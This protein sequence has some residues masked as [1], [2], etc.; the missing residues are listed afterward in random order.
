[1]RY[2]IQTKKI[3]LMQDIPDSFFKQTIYNDIT[4]SL[5]A[6]TVPVS[7]QNPRTFLLEFFSF[8]YLKKLILKKKKLRFFPGFFYATESG[9]GLRFRI[10][11]SH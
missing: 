5:T 9:C 10:H 4:V 1:M 3:L 7:D 2:R 11:K 8:N 6:I